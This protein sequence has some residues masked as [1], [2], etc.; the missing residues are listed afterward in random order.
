ML[1]GIDESNA[2]YEKISTVSTLRS[3]SIFYADLAARYQ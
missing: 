3:D 1:G 2:A